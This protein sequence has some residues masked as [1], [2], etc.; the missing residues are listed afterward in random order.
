MDGSGSM[1]L[2]VVIAWRL[3]GQKEIRK[4]CALCIRSWVGWQLAAS[5]PQLSSKYSVGV[6]EQFYVDVT[7]R[8]VSSFDSGVRPYLVCVE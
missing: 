3:E 1:S 4:R 7:G 5:I 2:L 8:P 6:F